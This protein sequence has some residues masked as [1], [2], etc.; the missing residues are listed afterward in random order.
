[1]IKLKPITKHITVKR[2]ELAAL[3]LTIALFLCL[4]F[5]KYTPSNITF[6]NDSAFSFA[7]ARLELDGHHPLLGPPS[8][9]GGRHLGPVYYWA[10]AFSLWVTQGH[11]YYAILVLLSLML[12][13]CAITVTIATSLAPSGTRLAAAIGTVLCLCGEIYL[14]Q[15]R[16]PWHGNFLFL[17]SAC[18]FLSFLIGLRKGPRYLPLY[19]LSASFLITTHYGCAPLV[20]GT[21]ATLVAYWIVHKFNSELA[22]PALSRSFLFLGI[23][24]PLCLSLLLWLPLITYEV[25]YPSNLATL[26]HA[27]FKSH[28]KQAGLWAGVTTFFGFLIH[29]T[30]LAEHSQRA[31]S[32]VSVASYYAAAGLTTLFMVLFIGHIRRIT[33]TSQFFYLGM[34][35]SSALFIVSASRAPSAPPPYPPIYEYYFNGLLPLPA[36]LIG[37]AFSQAASMIK[38]RFQTLWCW[39]PKML[40]IGRCLPAYIFLPFFVLYAIPGATSL[41]FLE[42]VDFSYY[43]HT[44]RQAKCVAGYIAKDLPENGHASLTVDSE[45]IWMKNSYLY[46][47]GKEYYG[48]MEVYGKGSPLLYQYLEELSPL[49]SLEANNQKLVQYLVSCPYVRKAR[50]DT[51][52]GLR[53][54]GFAEDYDLP[55]PNNE[56]CAACKIT[57]LTLNPALKEQVKE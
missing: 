46:F 26:A 5:E 39:P 37:I 52:S 47:M 21:G 6:M 16:E 31:G 57:R 33:K 56:A 27:F 24:L 19:I 43:F 2:V 25:L 3:A 8:H 29:H 45:S 55:I 38:G 23:G 35:A 34:L 30:F 7:V 4:V 48:A 42:K 36:L 11:D 53:R 15:V 22:A 14:M 18:V 49:A 28:H 40:P 44:F 13:A 41:S 20:V 32:V 12:L 9:I 50:A 51:M 54:L 17:P 1:M 10:V